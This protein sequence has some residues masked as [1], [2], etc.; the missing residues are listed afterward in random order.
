MGYFGGVDLASVPTLERWSHGSELYTNMTNVLGRK[1]SICIYLCPS[2]VCAAVI[3][4]FDQ[5]Q[6]EGDGEFILAARSQSII[7]ESW[8][9]WRTLFAGSHLARLLIF[10]KSP[11][12]F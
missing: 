1:N 3:K 7:E 4:H 11:F 9:Q 10:L 6:V 2:L 8:K 12:T 5:K